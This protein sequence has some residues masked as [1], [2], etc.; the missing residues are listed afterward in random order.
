MIN[1]I[2]W[3]LRLT[4]GPVGASCLRLNKKVGT[5]LSGVIDTAYQGKM[6][7]PQHAGG[8]KDYV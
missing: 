1:S 3:Q 5:V 6:W 8:R 7:F 2:N 4:P